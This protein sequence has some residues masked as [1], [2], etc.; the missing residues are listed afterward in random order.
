VSLVARHLEANGMPTVVIGS[1]LD[2][3]E[4]CGVPRFLF[5]DF[6]LGNPCGPPDRRDLQEAIVR[7]GISLLETADRPR[8][9]VKSPV[10]W[11]TEPGSLW[12]PRYGRVEPAER[13][14]L[15]ALGEERR[16]RWAQRTKKA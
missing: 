8:V 3:V 2:V 5:V 15:L 1:A 9:T 7:Q 14:R 4:Q 13:D 16:K 10:A 6:P 11:P 12:R